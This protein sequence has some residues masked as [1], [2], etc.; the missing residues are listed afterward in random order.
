[1]TKIR[2]PAQATEKEKLDALREKRLINRTERMEIDLDDALDDSFPASD[3]PSMT[4]PMTQP[5]KEVGS[6]SRKSYR[7]TIK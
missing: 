7:R 6:P 4:Q 2:I 5:E 3:P 1:M